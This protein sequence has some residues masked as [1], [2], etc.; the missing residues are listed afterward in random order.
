MLRQLLSL[1]PTIPESVKKLFDQGKRKGHQPKE[2][3]LLEILC[4]VMA[5]SDGTYLVLDALDECPMREDLIE[6]VTDLFRKTKEKANVFITSRKEF[7]IEEA[8]SEIQVE[9][10]HRIDVDNQ[11]VQVDIE[12]FVRSRLS[13]DRRLRKWTD[14]EPKVL[15]VLARKA[16]GM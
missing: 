10:I 1:K 6:L 16:G 4:E 13:T 14:Q 8:L 3:Q 2:T 7:D 12:N 5:N 11:C 9:D 15:D